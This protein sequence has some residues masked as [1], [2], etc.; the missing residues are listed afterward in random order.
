MTE[1]EIIEKMQS[2]CEESL[3]PDNFERWEKV[4]EGLELVRK[5]LK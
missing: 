1:K 5:N 3:S 2:M 4:K